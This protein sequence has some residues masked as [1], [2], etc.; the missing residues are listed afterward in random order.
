MCDD[1]QLYN[2]CVREFMILACTWFAFSLP[3]KTGCDKQHKR[4]PLHNSIMFK[5]PLVFIAFLPLISNFFVRQWGLKATSFSI[6]VLNAKGGEIRAKATWSIATCEFL[7]L[8][9]LVLVFWSKPSWYKTTL[10]W[11]E[12]FIMGKGGVFSF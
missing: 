7:K 12:I 11:G 6:L 4:L 9:C 2:C 1:V 8:L 10:L 5:L 3:S